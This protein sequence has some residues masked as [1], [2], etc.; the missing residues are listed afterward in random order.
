MLRRGPGRRRAPLPQRGGGPRVH[1]V[2]DRSGQPAWGHPQAR[3]R[4]CR[5]R[6]CWLA[7]TT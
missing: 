4:R 5:A 3:R 6:Q 1:P 7:R 2:P